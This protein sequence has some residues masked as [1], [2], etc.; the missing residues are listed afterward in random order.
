MSFDRLA[1][2]DIESEHV[3]KSA[4]ELWSR[5]VSVRRTVM[6]GL[7]AAAVCLLLVQIDPS[8]SDILRPVVS[9]CSKAVARIANEQPLVVDVVA[10]EGSTLH[11]IDRKTL[12]LHKFDKRLRST[13]GPYSTLYC[14]PHQMYFSQES[15]SVWTDCV[16]RG[17]LDGWALTSMVTAHVPFVAGASAGYALACTYLIGSKRMM[18]FV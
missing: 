5:Q 8:A 1:P 15:M 11:N 7:A 13:I 10:S 3:W 2:T 18:N 9:R 4:W 12:N 16:E 14:Y 17:D 6:S